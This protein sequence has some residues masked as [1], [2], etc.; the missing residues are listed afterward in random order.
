MRGDSSKEAPP[1]N[2][3][4]TVLPVLRSRFALPAD[5]S[6]AEACL[7][8]L[9]DLVREAPEDGELRRELARL[10]EATAADHRRL[11][12][13]LE[14]EWQ[15]ALS[16]FRKPGLPRP[17]AG[18]LSHPLP[19]F[20]LELAPSGHL[21]LLLPDLLGDR[22]WAQRVSSEGR[23]AAP[24]R[25]LHVTLLQVGSRRAFEWLQHRLT[26]PIAGGGTLWLGHAH[27]VAYRHRDLDDLTQSANLSGLGAPSEEVRD[28]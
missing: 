27:L 8:E 28:V 14:G 1:E 18:D 4:L 25:T 26:V 10:Q 12:A 16:F 9:A 15:S 7:A 13:L 2:L 3:H 19:S 20:D 17:R 22:E 6:Q 21:I 24:E 5:R 23:F 11:Q